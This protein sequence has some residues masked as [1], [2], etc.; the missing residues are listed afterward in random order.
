MVIPL[1]SAVLK[2]F[3]LRKIRPELIST[4]NPSLFAEEDWP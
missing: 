4:T 3:F 2:L 1:E